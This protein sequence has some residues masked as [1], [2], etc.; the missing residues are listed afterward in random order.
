MLASFP[1]DVIIVF[2]SSLYATCKLVSH[3]KRRKPTVKPAIPVLTINGEQLFTVKVAA[4]KLGV[5]VATVLK[6]LKN[7][8]ISG[9]KI[10]KSWRLRDCDLIPEMVAD[11]KER[12]AKKLE[13]VTP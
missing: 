9:K 4:E 1:Q 11:A 13:S 3:M 2:T 6:M 7:K 5:C 8:E 12:A 10:R